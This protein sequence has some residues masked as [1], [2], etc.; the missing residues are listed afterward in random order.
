MMSR[1]HTRL[2]PLAAAAA[3]CSG[4]AFALDF[5]GY[6]RSGGGSNSEDGGQVCFALPGTPGLTG[7]KYRL[8]NE[9]DTYAELGFTQELFESK[10][11]GVKFIY[12]GMLSYS[13]NNNDNSDSYASLV[14]DGD[15]A[16]RQNYIEVKN[17]PMMNGA[18]VWVGKRYYQRQDIH[19]NDF[20]YWDTSGTGFGVE[21]YKIGDS[22]LNLSYALFRNT[23]GQDTAATRHDF[24]VGGIGLGAYGDLTLGLQY[25]TAD[26]SV[27][28]ND[29]N[30]WGFTVQHF[31]GGVLGGFNKAALQYS[32]GTVAQFDYGYPATDE[33]ANSD[34]AKKWRFVEILNWQ[35]TP[36]F[37]GM[38]TFIYQKSD[39]PK[40]DWI[41]FNGTWMSAGV[42]PV[43]AI[44]DYFRIVAELGHDRIKPND[45]ASY[46]KTINLTKF[47]IA[48]TLAVGPSFWA[49]PELRLFYTYAKWN[50]A[51]RDIYA[52]AIAGGKFGTAT[53]GSTIGFQVE[54]WW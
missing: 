36:K 20:Y 28:A 50:E 13:I 41:G 6:L 10:K 8:G 30:G 37:G 34:G 42:R 22:G 12:H 4:S 44:N 47:T 3:L 19:I 24:R 53:H 35:T 23:M 52:G 49:R 51:A 15:I 26:T 17:L 5:N 14:D 29:N 25:N 1:L 21:G 2:L 31:K 11:D 32:K 40:S 48:P 33:M 54:A 16:A 38:A 45:D 7:T 46:Q 39:T 18:A 27:D 9:C 43:Y